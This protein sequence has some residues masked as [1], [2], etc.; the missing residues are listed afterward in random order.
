MALHNKNKMRF[1]FVYRGASSV[2]DL[3]TT[4]F[5]MA[6]TCNAETDAATVDDL[7]ACLDEELEKGFQL[8]STRL[9]TNKDTSD[10]RIWL[11]FFPVADL[12]AAGGPVFVDVEQVAPGSGAAATGF[13]R[14]AAARATLNEGRAPQNCLDTTPAS[15]KQV[16]AG[17]NNDQEGNAEDHP[18]G[19]NNYN[20]EVNGDKKPAL[21]TFLQE[22]GKQMAE[23]V[24]KQQNVKETVLPH[25]QDL[26]T[27]DPSKL[28]NMLE[29][30]PMLS[31]LRGQLS[32][33]D[34]LQKM[35]QRMQE[36]LQSLQG[37]GA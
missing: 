27:G 22:M 26:A 10:E 9:T 21:P 7:V 8:K 19:K 5:V 4:E 32:D 15:S 12:L 28:Q 2:L 16:Q 3:D 17:M 31:H 13:P 23:T 33:P 20:T 30:H 11:G 29:N 34:K 6:A 1:E 37:S 14:S 24:L 36:R 18:R 25:L 35:Q